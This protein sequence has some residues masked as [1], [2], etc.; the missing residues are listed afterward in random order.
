MVLWRAIAAPSNRPFAFAQGLERS[1]PTSLYSYV[2]KYFLIA[3]SVVII[4]KVA[5]AKN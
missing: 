5:K 3:N 4:L 1:D 2:F